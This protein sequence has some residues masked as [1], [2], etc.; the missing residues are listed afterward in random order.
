MTNTVDFIFD[1]ASP[2]AYFSY[3][4]FPPILERTN[5]SLNL[6]PCLL[7]GIFKATG[8]QAPM[9]AFAGVKGKLEYDRVEI[10]R[11]IKK[12]GLSDFVFNPN[13]P[14]NTLLLMRG[15]IAAEMDGRLVEY[16]EAGLK[17][18]WEDGRKMDDPEVFVSA[19]GEAGFD[20]A[21]LLERTQ[22]PAVK[23]KLVANTAAA[24]ARG[25]FGVPTFYVGDEMFFGKD[26]LAQ[27]EDELV[28]QG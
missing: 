28:A 10:G 11:F 1:F 6:I 18:M 26:R 12:H 21:N 16:T 13:F 27:V 5:A 17:H 22:D 15:A 19:M 4:A 14:V 7:G 2:N 25:A 20:G 9:L 3:K 23:A 8:N 24:V